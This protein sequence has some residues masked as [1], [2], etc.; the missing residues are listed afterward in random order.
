MLPLLALW[1]ACGLWDRSEPTTAT[2]PEPELLTF[3]QR[4]PEGMTLLDRPGDAG[5]LLARWP[6]LAALDEGPR[7]Q[8]IGT[9]NVVPA[10]C[11]PCDGQ[12]LGGCAIAPPPGCE[13]VEGL[14]ARVARLATEGA[15][16]EV[17]RAA[18][19]YADHWVPQA[20][21]Q[22]MW[23]VGPKPV[24]LEVWTHPGSPFRDLVKE[25]LAQLATTPEHA[26]VQVVH[27]DLKAEP[28]VAARRGLRSAPTYFVNGHRLRGAQSAPTIMRL[29]RMELADQEGTL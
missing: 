29:I 27:R 5:A 3:E 18:V 26:Q 23:A 6:A 17:L 24:T 19:S 7:Q 9:L 28:E 14:V 22:P 10:P 4:K 2:E 11:T 25:T 8:V 13:I 20:P 1:A 15:P 21:R 16:P 12:S